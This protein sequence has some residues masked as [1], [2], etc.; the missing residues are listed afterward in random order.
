MTS[1]REAVR[2]VVQQR[3]TELGT[4]GARLAKLTGLSRTTIRY[5]GEAERK[6][7]RGEMTS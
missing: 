1:D 3:R 6:I 2:A 4:S 7:L 5:L